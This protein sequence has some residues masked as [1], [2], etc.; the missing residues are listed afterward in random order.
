MQHQSKSL[1]L[2]ACVAALL[3]A[4]GQAPRS[5]E[6]PTVPVEGLTDP[7]ALEGQVQRDGGAITIKP[8]P[9]RLAAQSVNEAYSA[10]K[11]IKVAQVKPPVTST[12][13]ELRAAQVDVVG[14]TVTVAYNHEGSVF[15]GAV[16]VFDVTSMQNPKL[17]Y[18]A[19]FPDTKINAA[20][21]NLNGKLYLAGARPVDVSGLPNPSLMLELQ[22][23]NNAATQT[24][25]P[26]WAGTD[27]A[28]V[29]SHLFFTGG[30]SACFGTGD[31]VGGTGALE[32]ASKTRSFV[33]AH[34]NAQSVDVGSSEDGD[35]DHEA[36]DMKVQTYGEKEDQ[37]ANARVVALQAGQAGKLRVFKV[38]N[39]KLASE[40]KQ[41]AGQTAAATR[42]ISATISEIQAVTGATI[43]TITGIGATI[44][45]LKG[46]SYRV[47]RG[48]DQPAPR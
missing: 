18:R 6:E 23:G 45:K 38:K 24:G 3:A 29:G 46:K 30:N 26:G 16:D 40:V 19:V 4:C 32:V 1:I 2:A 20:T 11:F 8:L 21:N 14:K 25:L 41:L 22:Q 7:N 44:V 12:G 43:G 15:A 13:I 39:G 36:E 33:D 47:H 5:V 27:L 31:R 35:D 17:V 37:T 34:C 10:Y 28:L 9:G 48:A 42:G